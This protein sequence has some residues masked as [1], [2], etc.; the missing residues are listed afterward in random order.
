VDDHTTDAEAL[1]NRALDALENAKQAG[2]NSV[3]CQ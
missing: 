3:S 1:L 2:G